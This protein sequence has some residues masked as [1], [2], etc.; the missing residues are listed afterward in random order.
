MNKRPVKHKDK[1]LALIAVVLGAAS[2]SNTIFTGIP[3]II[4][5][6]IALKKNAGNPVQAK[7]GI[8][9]GVIGSL[10]LVPIIWLGIHFLRE[11]F[12]EQYSVG[13]EDTSRMMKITEA[14]NAYKEKEGRYPFCKQNETE[15]TCSDWIQLSRRN[16]GLITYSVAFET[17]SYAIEDRSIN[18][19]VYATETTCFINTPAEPGYL[20]DDSDLVPTKRENY[21]AIIFFHSGGRSCYPTNTDR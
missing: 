11:P 13:K 20:D 12:S 4:L 14:L 17:A 8:L 6:I 10:I 15:L 16:P 2:F 18:T 19:I 9:F 1:N 5:G 21:A 3:A 7:L